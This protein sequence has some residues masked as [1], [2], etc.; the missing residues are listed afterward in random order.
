MRCGPIRQ[1]QE[2]RL[3]ADLSSLERRAA[4]GSHRRVR[5][6]LRH[7][8]SQ[9]QGSSVLYEL[10]MAHTLAKKVIILTQTTQDIP[11][12]I[13]PFRHT[14]YQHND[15]GYRALRRE[16][17]EHIRAIKRRASLWGTQCSPFGCPL[18]HPRQR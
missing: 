5:A 3:R 10:A 9:S 14:T 11:F 13:S 18:R 8:V 7:T 2:D 1:R 12:D 17:P 6:Q 4:Q 16:L 15:D